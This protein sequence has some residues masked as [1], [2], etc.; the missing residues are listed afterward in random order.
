[1]Y[2][3]GLMIVYS[4][5]AHTSHTNSHTYND[6]H[7]NIVIHANWITTKQHRYAHK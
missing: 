1:M 6:W 2:V 4:I 5:H 3:L 7:M